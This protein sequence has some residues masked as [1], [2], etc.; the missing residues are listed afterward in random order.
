MHH[1][2]KLYYTQFP[3]SLFLTKRRSIVYFIYIAIFCWFSEATVM[4]KIITREVA[5]SVPQISFMVAPNVQLTLTE[6]GR[7][8]S[9]YQMNTMPKDLARDM[10]NTPK[11]RDWSNACNN[12]FRFIAIILFFHLLSLFKCNGFN[13]IDFI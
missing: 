3:A 6:S 1:I 10:K 5:I 13:N 2:V 4:Q 9:T 8:L 11:L 7:W 12:P